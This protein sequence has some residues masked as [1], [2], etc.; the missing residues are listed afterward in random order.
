MLEIIQ[1][2]N[3]LTFAAMSKINLHIRVFR[4]IVLMWFIL[5]S[6]SPCT[7]KEA[8]FNWVSI[9]YTKPLNKSKTTSSSG[10]CTFSQRGNEQISPAK[11]SE[12]NQEVGSANSIDNHGVAV[13]SAKIFDNYFIPLQAI[14]RQN[15]FYT[16]D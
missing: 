16:N 7:V 12:V 15:T 6:L 13:Y 5:L 8:V 11:K 4:R 9:E 14:A 1:Q 10:A 3:R 2:E